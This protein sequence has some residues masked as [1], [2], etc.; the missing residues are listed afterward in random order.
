LRKIYACQ[1]NLGD[2]LTNKD[3]SKFDREVYRSNPEQFIS[4]FDTKVSFLAD[5]F[6]SELDAPYVFIVY[7]TFRSLPIQLYS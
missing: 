3:G 6:G 2:Y 7:F 5:V 1:L 4:E